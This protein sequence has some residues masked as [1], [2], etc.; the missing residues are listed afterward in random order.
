M[1]QIRVVDEGGNPVR[2]AYLEDEN[3]K[4]DFHYLGTES[5]SG[6]EIIETVEPA[7]FESIVSK[8]GADPMKDILTIIQEVSDSGRGGE[9]IKALKSQEIINKPHKWRRD[10]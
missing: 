2:Y 9:L 10:K 5:S 4:F 3:L 8:F 7:D 1:R 6:Y